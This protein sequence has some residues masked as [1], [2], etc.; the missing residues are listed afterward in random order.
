[1]PPLIRRDN[2][3]ENSDT[4]SRFH[5][6]RPSGVFS[7]LL[8]LTVGASCVLLVLCTRSSNVAVLI[9]MVALSFFVGILMNHC[10]R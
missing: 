4:S 2:S 1:M 6:C 8:Q 3:S 9:G 5:T 10:L 7:L